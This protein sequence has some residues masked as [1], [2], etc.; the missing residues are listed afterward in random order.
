MQITGRQ[1]QASNGR[2]T[3]SIIKNISTW[4][5][6][7][8]GKSKQSGFPYINAL[9]SYVIFMLFLAKSV[10]MRH[11]SESVGRRDR[12]HAQYLQDT[13]SSSST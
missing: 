11:A 6:L 8:A 3:V 2:A 13:V 12:E 5:V 4:V 9:H 10:N 7:T 1:R